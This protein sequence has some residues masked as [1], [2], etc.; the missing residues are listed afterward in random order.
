[1]DLKVKSVAAV[2]DDE[3][4]QVLARRLYEATP[5][6]PPRGGWENLLGMEKERFRDI[7]RGH[8]DAVTP[9]IVAAAAPHA[10]APL[11]DEDYSIILT[12]LDREWRWDLSDPQKPSVISPE[13]RAHLDRIEELIKRVTAMRAASAD[14]GDAGPAARERE[15]TYQAFVAGAESA[16]VDL[17]DPERQFV[18]FWERQVDHSVDAGLI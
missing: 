15:M 8:L 1:M 4:V 13:I 14:E 16:G 3:A 7:A 2:R 18:A 6:H 11:A 5:G 12:L 9:L 17:E 10:P